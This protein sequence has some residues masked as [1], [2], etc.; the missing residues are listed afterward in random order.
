MSTL[1]SYERGEIFA[2]TKPFPCLRA[3]PLKGP[4]QNRV[5]PSKVWRAI[6]ARI[7]VGS[8]SS[9]HGLGKNWSKEREVGPGKTFGRI[10]E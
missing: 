8:I 10:Q 7:S 1:I 9:H 4:V 3:W 6:I 2:P 5:A